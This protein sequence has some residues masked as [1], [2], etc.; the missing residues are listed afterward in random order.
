[1]FLLRD[2]LQFR[3]QYMRV[4]GHALLHPARKIAIHL[5]VKNQCFA[6]IVK[7]AKVSDITRCY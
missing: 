6:S 1:M 4:L 7:T 3:F 5:I 2:R